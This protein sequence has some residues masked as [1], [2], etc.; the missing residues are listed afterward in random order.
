MKKE[1]IFWGILLLI[2]GIFLVISKLGYFSDI[3]AISIVFSVFLVG[4]II[5]SIISISFAGILFPLAFL[6]II[7]DEQLG[8]TAITPWTVLLAALLGSIG[9]SLIFSKRKYH[10]YKKTS[11][12]YESNDQV[13]T[14]EHNRV[15]INNSF[16][17]TVKYINSDNFEYGEVDCAFGSVK[18]YFDKVQ[19]K[20]ERAELHLSISFSGM[21]LYIPKGWQIENK[22]VSSFG[23]IREKNVNK[24]EVITNTL[25]LTGE[26]TFS[27]VDIIY[28]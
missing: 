15:K 20:S 3:N 24:S 12:D 16:T 10:D 1:R 9:L 25:V 22:A 14:D 13:N 4:I 2:S 23:T 11:V 19:I 8:I 21:E 18:V 28:I 17:S 5:K 26:V 6:A 27:G 7:Y